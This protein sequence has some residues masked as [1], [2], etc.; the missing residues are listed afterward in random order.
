MLPHQL[1]NYLQ[2]PAHSEIDSSNTFQTCGKAKSFKWSKI[3]SGHLLLRNG[4][5]LQ[6]PHASPVVVR[7]HLC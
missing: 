6:D 7:G 5:T 3:S 1:Y 2:I 4:T